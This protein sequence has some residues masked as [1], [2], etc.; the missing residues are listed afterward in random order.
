M[1][2]LMSIEFENY[3]TTKSKRIRITKTDFDTIVCPARDWGVEQVFLTEKRWY[4][5]TIQKKY[6]EK[7]KY[8]ALYETRMKSIRYVGKIKKITPF[9]NTKKFQIILDG[10]P[11]KIEPIRRSKDNPHKAPQN[12]VYTKFELFK[13]AKILEDIF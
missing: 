13:N 12:K 4:A 6:F 9:E 2:S 1:L 10:N 3:P 11:M 8:I 7:I 5:V